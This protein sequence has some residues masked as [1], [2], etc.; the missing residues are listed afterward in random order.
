[1]DYTDRFQKGIVPI[2]LKHGI[3]LIDLKQGLYRYI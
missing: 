3:I 1:M 2:D